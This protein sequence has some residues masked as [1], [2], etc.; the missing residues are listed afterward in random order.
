MC[1][2]NLCLISVKYGITSVIFFVYFYLGIKN[3]NKVHSNKFNLF[4][5]EIQ[6]V[7]LISRS[8]SIYKKIGKYSLFTSLPVFVVRYILISRRSHLFYFLSSFYSM[9]STSKY[10]FQSPVYIESD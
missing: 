4:S 2:K 3:V 8:C 9:P 5:I 1:E 6:S 10:S 7:E